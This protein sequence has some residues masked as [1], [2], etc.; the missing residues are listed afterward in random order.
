ACSTDGEFFRRYA[1]RYPLPLRQRVARAWTDNQ[2]RAIHADNDD[3]CVAAGAG[4]G[5]T[6]V[7]VERFVR[8]VTQ[9]RRGALPPERRAGV[10]EILVITFT[11]KATKEMKSRIVAELNRLG[12]V[13]E[14]RQVETA[15]IST[16][17]GFCSRLLQENPFEAGVDPQF[18]VLDEV[19]ARRLLR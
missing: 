14:R 11:E 1:D 19:Q 12:L 4:S 16:I 3:I 2:A 6:G 17:H 8:L 13:D 15:Y 5:K 18:T 9:S 7:L 10:G